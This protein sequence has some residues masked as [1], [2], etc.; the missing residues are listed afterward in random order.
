MLALAAIAAGVASA[1]AQPESGDPGPGSGARVIVAVLP[2]GLPI[3]ELGAVPGV[4]PGVM[5][6]G[7]GSVPP[8]QSFLDIGQG[9]RVNQSLYDSEILPV[10]VRNGRLRPGVWTRLR[11]RADDAPADVVPGLLGSTLKAAGFAAA[12]EAAD[13]LAPLI[14]ADE[15]GRI[16]LVRE[17][18][19]PDACPRGLTVVRTDLHLFDDLVAGLEEDEL[20][21]AFA[22]GSRS[23][24]QLWPTAIA[25]AGFD[26]NLTSDSTRTDGVVLTTDVAPTI[27]EWLGVGRPDEMNGSAIRAEG[28]T[29]LAA[30][31]DLQDR[32][33]DRPSR[34]PVVLLPLLAWLALAAAVAAALR[35]RGARAAFRLFGLACAWAPSVLLAA[36]ALD[37]GELVS[38][39]MMG[40]G[41]PALAAATAVLVPGFGGLALACAV[42]VGV[43][44]IDVVA[45]SPYTSLSVL[46]PNPGGGVRFFGIGNE[47]EATLTTLT[48]IGTGAWLTARGSVDRRTA[49]AW[50]LGIAALATLAFA[51]GR[52]G[53]D[54]GAAIVL[55]S[56]GATAAVL[57]LR[58]PRGLAI[59]LVVGG[60]ALAL[61]ALLLIDL[62]FGGA[63][64]SRSVLGA[65]EAGAL[66]DVLERRLSL[67][68]NTFLHP[69]YPELLAVAALLLAV[70]FA[71]RDAVRG[72]FGAAWAARCGF[73]GALA[74]VL[75][76]TLANDSGTVLLVI[77]TIF[78]GAGAAF[79][80]GNRRAGADRSI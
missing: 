43:H 24:Q 65:G 9:N 18:T 36:A 39:L 21:I 64:L 2:Y 37:A 47:L 75:I 51:P 53:A 20:L 76:G 52:F 59:G 71:R 46:G 42:T 26:G 1:H 22:A 35:G 78:L 68:A 33:A 7:L 54:V 44:A 5:S 66:A 49:A 34:A 41:A 8:A 16:D 61:G 50:F 15:R 23:E 48:L 31:A 60:G 72:W 6:A 62:A 57:A 38:A 69:V 25:G 58:L 19:C 11:E 73:L 63:H 30:V 10:Y 80:W 4:A 40:L 79:A 77:G 67:M 56:G 55:G 45:G 27:L 74:G 70:G 17:G 3:E 14:A 13:G 32:L 28:E 12:S 29:D